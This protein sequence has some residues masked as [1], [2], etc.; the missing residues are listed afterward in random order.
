MKKNISCHFTRMLLMKISHL[1]LCYIHSSEKQLSQMVWFKISWRKT[2]KNYKGELLNV[3]CF[4]NIATI[5]GHE[6]VHITS[7]ALSIYTNCAGVFWI[8]L[9]RYTLDLP[10]YQNK[11]I[12][13]RL[14]FKCIRIFSASSTRSNVSSLF[15]KIVT[16]FKCWYTTD[17]FFSK[18]SF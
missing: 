4:L 11:V 3:L 1:C 15:R 14:S 2:R 8:K 12:P 17:F 18:Y 7:T 16:L 9:K 10:L 5:L 6:V 13:K